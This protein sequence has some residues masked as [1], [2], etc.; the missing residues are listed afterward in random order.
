MTFAGLSAVEAD[1]LTDARRYLDLTRAAFGRGWIFFRELS[2]YIEAGI[3]WREGDLAAALAAM[4]PIASELL[5][6]EGLLM[7][8]FVLLDQVELS[9]E[10][11]DA[12]GAREAVLHLHEIPRT[13]GLDV[14]EGLQPLAAA[15]S[16]LVA[17]QS[18]DAAAHA[19]R[20]VARLTD[21]GCRAFLARA[22]EV[23][24]RSLASFD[25]DGSADAARE[26]A[27]LFDI[28]GAVSRRDRMLAL[29]SE[30]RGVSGL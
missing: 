13:E 28:C 9:A 1:R 4:R 17:D 16:S 20:A 24:A 25:R 14:V 2:D 18:E 23:L 12:D 5:A 27:G 21:L 3:M 19:R 29:L 7:A 26:A 30:Q 15:W 6:K 22:L 8:S 11:G 10:M